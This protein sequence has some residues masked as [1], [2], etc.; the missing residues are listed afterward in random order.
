MVLV[1]EFVLQV[2]KEGWRATAMER[3]GGIRRVFR[4][5][6]SYRGGDLGEE[7]DQSLEEGRVGG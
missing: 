6:R 5:A 4:R 1:G 7:V 3:R 2:G